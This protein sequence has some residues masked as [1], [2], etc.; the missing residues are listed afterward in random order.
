MGFLLRF[1]SLVLLVAAVLAGILDSVRTVSEGRVVLASLGAVIGMLEPFWPGLVN[2]AAPAYIDANGGAWAIQLFALPA[3][4]VFLA[5]SLLFWIAG[6]RRQRRVWPPF[7][8]R[9]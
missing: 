8:G 4:A 1:L 3:F 6:Y 2:G 9:A 7:S 5:V